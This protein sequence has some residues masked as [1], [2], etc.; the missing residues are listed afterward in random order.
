MR[1]SIIYSS[2]RALFVAIFAIIGI[3]L[4]FF[5]IL[6]VIGAFVASSSSSITDDT[7]KSH[8]KEQVL[9]NADWSRTIRSKESPVIF[10]LNIDGVIGMESLTAQNIRQQ[11]IESREGDLKNNRIKALLLYIN[12]PGGTVVDSNGI[13]EVLKEYK[14]KF[15]V[16]IYA[17]VDGMCASGGMY[18]AAAADKIYAN[19]VALIGSVGVLLP[20]FWNVAPLLEKIGVN[21]LTL[22]AGKDKDAMSP[23]RP[24]KEGEQ[25][26]YQNLVNYY[27]QMFVNIVTSNR[28][29]VSKEKLIN[30][31]GAQ[32]YPAAEAVKMGY[33]D[34]DGS[35]RDD[36]LRALVKELNLEDN[37][38][39]VVQFESR[40]WWS[41]LF[42]NR[43]PLITGVI[44]HE[45]ELSSEYPVE[46]QNKYL[47][48]Y[49]P[50]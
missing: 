19:E 34:F 36:V 7:A 21:T 30:E 31:Y 6:M 40:D 10:Q 20:P 45:L 25:N 38:Y 15:Q 43:S 12:T 16:P 29:Q 18:I 9:A 35:S 39:Q 41:S 27:Y 22:S 47:Y 5:L 4:G 26:N 33:I 48:L 11:L 32:V 14:A 13:Y 37:N 2:F 44:K 23:L 42:N 28:P 49:K 50:N 17:Y 46:L 3:I 1:D 8:F 24:W